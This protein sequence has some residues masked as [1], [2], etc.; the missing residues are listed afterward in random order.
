LSDYQSTTFRAVQLGLQIRDA[1]DK[2]SEGNW[3]R[4][5]NVRSTQEAQLDT[6]EGLI[7]VNDDDPFG[8]FHSIRRLSTLV[9]V[10]GVGPRLHRDAFGTYVNPLTGTEFTGFSGNPLSLVP[11]QG[12]DSRAPWMFVGD[13]ATLRKAGAGAN[14]QFYQWGVDPPVVAVTAAPFGAAGNLN[15]SV[16]GAI[17]YEWRYTYRSS[18]T[19]AESN[20]SPAMAF[21]VSVVNQQAGLTGA[22]STDPQVDQI[23]WWRR[24]GTLTGAEYRLVGT[25]INTSG[26]G[27]FFDDNTADSALVLQ[28]ILSFDKWRPFQSVDSTG[29]QA[30]VN[31]PYL[32]SFAGKYI[33]GCGD[34]NRPGYLYWTNPGD[35]DSASTS[36]NVQITSQAEA[37]TAVFVYDGQ[38]FCWTKDNLYPIQF[39]QDIVTFRGQLSSCGRGCA[40]PWAYTAD[41]PQIF[42][43]SQDG[44]YATDGQSPAVSLTEGSLRPIFNGLS[45]GNFTPV[46]YTAQEEL[47]MWFAGQKLHFVYKDTL[48]DR[49]HLTWHSAYN[50]WELNTYF[51]GAINNAPTTVYEDEGRS[52]SVVYLGFSSGFLYQLEPNAISDAGSPIVAN[53][54]TGSY[55]FG[56]P[57]ALKEFG[58]LIVDADP[59]GGTITVTPYINAEETALPALLCTGTGRQKFTFG[60][61]D[62]YAY[63]LAL[64]Y[65]WSGP[66]TI[67]QAEVLHRQ[68]EER[69]VHWEFPATTFGLSGWIQLRDGYI[70]LLSDAPVSITVQ[71]DNVTWGPY[72]IPSTGGTRLKIYF[73]TDAIKAKVFRISLNSAQP[74]RLYG[75]DCEL[76]VKPWNTDLGY[77]LMSPFRPS[78]RETQ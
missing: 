38:P 78:N 11:F 3:V 55:D 76:R 17:P 8:P 21:G 45:V 71:A 1:N 48:G 12:N 7:L 10:W 47:R 19:G 32:A 65:A 20:P 31:L 4:L 57:Q 50:R 42:F 5:E 70:D 23:R 51:P 61:D 68:D 66:G 77:A 41:G 13:T 30:R 29:A 36:N 40:A 6:R 2:V 35:P 54:R 28:E 27:V 69:I 43:L 53:V 73:Q 63:S 72:T 46:D 24:G 52:S 64:D 18:T 60:L 22:G 49:Q 75:E 62:V 39:G 26:A 37:L 58:N 25:S 14:N 56:A 33:L 15:S 44:I 9:R 74:F 16:A 59:Q 34:P 67:Y